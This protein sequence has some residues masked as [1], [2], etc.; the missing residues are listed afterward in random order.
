M[1]GECKC[2]CIVK[3]GFGEYMHVR[4]QKLCDEHMKND[5]AATVCFVVGGTKFGPLEVPLRDG[6]KR[7]IFVEVRGKYECVPVPLEGS[8]REEDDIND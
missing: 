8:A 3:F 1:V 2:G 7:T 4:F 5:L 6:Y